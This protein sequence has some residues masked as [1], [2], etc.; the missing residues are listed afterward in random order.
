MRA[1]ILAAGLGTRL[2]SLSDERPK[3]LL[4][5]C[6]IPL[7]RYALA[8]LHGHGIREIAV[9]LHHRGDLIQ[10]ELGDEVVYSH[11]EV[12]LGT[13]GGLAKIGNWLT[14]GGKESFFVVNGKILVDADLDELRARHQRAD[15]SA[16][17]L[18]RETPDAKKWGAI[19]TDE[20]GHVTRII[21]TPSPE[22]RS[23]AHVCM[24]T[25]VHLIAPRLLSRLPSS[26]E[27]DSIRQAYLPAFEA[28][29]PIE[30]VLL[31]GYFHE[32]STPERYLEGNW[33]ALRGRAVLRHPPG[34][35]SGVDPTATV[36]GALHHP[37]LVGKQAVIAAGAHVGPDV[38]VGAGARVEAGARLERVVI[39]P[40]SVVSS[41]LRDAIV[42]PRGIS[43]LGGANG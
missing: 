14:N 16:T 25:G 8:L 20:Q 36:D 24:F 29:E 11:E 23:S 12:I 7:I 32:H 15:A 4:P 9:N 6:D 42:T 1:I 13:G 22:G 26:G 43:K 3:P 41:E 27:S 40:G 34:P 2:G 21:G 37:V 10:K 28:G 18:L 19:E 17:M 39:W 30:G 31:K 33:N 35:L 5:V 38:V